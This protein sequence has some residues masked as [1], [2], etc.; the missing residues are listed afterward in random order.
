MMG[1]HLPV[2]S[3]SVL[4]QAWRTWLMSFEPPCC[5]PFAAAPGACPLVTPCPV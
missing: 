1:L 2:C 4:Q 3:T 5:C